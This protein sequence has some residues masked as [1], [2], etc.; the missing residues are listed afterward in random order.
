MNK[1]ILHVCGGD[2]K[3]V[4]AC[5]VGIAYSPRMWRWSWCPSWECRV[6]WVF[7]TYV[8]VIP[9]N[10]YDKQNNASILHVC[11]GDPHTKVDWLNEVRYSPRM[12]RWS[13]APTT[14]N[15]SATV[16][17][18][19]VEVILIV[20]C[21]FYFPSRILHVCGGD[22]K[23]IT[24]SHKFFVY[25]PRMWR[26]SQP[27]KDHGTTRKSILHVCGGDPDGENILHKK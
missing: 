15:I 19:Y 27:W 10:V 17:S 7:S 21:S 26:W 23:G 24:A 2:P 8:E 20:S 5:W 9:Q 11:G 12:W 13:P 22:P 14:W 1:R 18:T 16:F 6:Q 4:I 25:S 3:I